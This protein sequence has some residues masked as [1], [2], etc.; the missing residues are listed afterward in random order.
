MNNVIENAVKHLKDEAI[1]RAEQQAKETIIKATDTME[2]N[3]WNFTAVA[4]MPSS[5]KD[6]RESYR[7]KN[8]VRAFY[9][10]L[11]SHDYHATQKA[12]D[13][14]VKNGEVEARYSAQ[15]LYNIYTRDEQKEAK[16]IEDAKRNAASQYD[17]FVAKLNQKIGVA[18]KA[19]LDGSHVWGHSFLEVVTESG[20]L[21]TW[22][23]QMIINVSKYGK[24]FNQFPTRKVKNRA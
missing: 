20:E 15:K 14:A 1:A 16:F 24:L 7:Q 11:F 19:T 6:S 22:K 8:A 23:T 18:K 4:P 9:N 3:N 17:A 10:N 2:Q 12:Y 5:F 21:Q 13:D